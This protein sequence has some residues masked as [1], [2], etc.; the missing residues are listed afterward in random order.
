SGPFCPPHAAGAAIA[1]PTNNA[2]KATRNTRRAMGFRMVDAFRTRGIGG[3][4][5]PPQRRAAARRGGGG[6]G[7]GLSG[8]AGGAARVGEGGGS[9]SPVVGAVDGVGSS[10]RRP[11]LR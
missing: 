4:P 3:G 1:P 2:A 9:Y 7:R 10:E 6:G 11:T 5:P 8:A